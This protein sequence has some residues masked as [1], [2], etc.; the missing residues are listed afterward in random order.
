MIRARD[1][2]AVSGGRGAPLAVA[3]A[4]TAGGKKG[5]KTLPEKQ[6][7]VNSPDGA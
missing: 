2:T 1:P 7:L 4:T 5:C 3:C 6:F